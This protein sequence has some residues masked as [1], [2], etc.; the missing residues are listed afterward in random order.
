MSKSESAL[1]LFKD[2][3]NCAQSVLGAFCEDYGMDL[4][5]ALKL[6]GGLGRGANCGEICGAVSGAVLV[7]GLKYG[8]SAQGDTDAK[9]ECSVRT[10]EFLEEFRAE[11]NTVICRELLGFDV[12]N[13]EERE[14]HLTIGEF[15]KKCNSAID[16]AA[17][18]LT[19]LGY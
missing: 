16:H 13:Q 15:I 5:T 18:I 17:T 2:G 4:D 1:K 10:A 3:F 19:D 14:K 12:S 7:I 11:N 6:S 8:Q 9:A